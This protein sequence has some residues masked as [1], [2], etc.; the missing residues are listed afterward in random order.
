MSKPIPFLIGDVHGCY[1]TLMALINKAENQV[2]RPL[3][4]ILLGDLID[5][6]PRSRE[7]VLWAMLNKIETCRA[8]HD[9]L[10]LAYSAHAK[11]GYKAKCPEYYDRDVWLHNGGIQALESWNPKHGQA[12]PREVLDWMTNLPPY[13]ILD[14]EREGRKCLASHTGYGLDADKGNWLRALWGRYPDDGEFMHQSGNGEPMDDGYLRAFGHT[15]TRSV[16]VTK[17]HVNLDS[18]A[19]YPGYG[20]LT[21]MLWPSREIVQVDY[22]D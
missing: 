2:D 21:G 6:G 7:V 14:G 3:R 8:N 15:K 13:I 4:V 22:C 12:L 16:E 20:K 18:G 19:A 10:C 11:L 9:D 5:R 1:R 17:T